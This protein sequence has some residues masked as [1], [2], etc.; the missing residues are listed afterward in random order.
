LKV[1]AQRWLKDERHRAAAGKG[2][3]G[4]SVDVQAVIAEIEQRDKRDQ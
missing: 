1:R 2:C 4:K 3:S